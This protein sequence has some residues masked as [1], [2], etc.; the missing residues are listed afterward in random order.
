MTVHLVI[1]TASLPYGYKVTEETPVVLPI[2]TAKLWSDNVPGRGLDFLREELE[3]LISL[4]FK[5][6]Y[7]DIEPFVRSWHSEV[8]NEMLQELVPFARPRAEMF[9]E[10]ERYQIPEV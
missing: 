10:F 1:A 3:R 9:A 6:L 7:P 4:R 5:K 8:S 2:S